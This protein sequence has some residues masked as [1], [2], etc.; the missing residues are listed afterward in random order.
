MVRQTIE[1]VD[2]LNIKDTQQWWDIFLSSIRSKTVEYIKQKHTVE[3]SARDAVRKGLLDIEAIP[4]DQ[5]SPRRTAHYTYLTEKLC[6]FEEMVVEGYRQ[7]TRG[8]PSTD[9]ANQTSHFMRSCSYE[10]PIAPLL[11]NYTIKTG[12]STLTTP[13]H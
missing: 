10:A 2:R 11:G 5:L 13:L 1:N 6:G 4:A 12:K 8:S 3:N 9:N 7:R